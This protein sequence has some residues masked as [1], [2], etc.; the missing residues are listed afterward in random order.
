MT[1]KKE[2]VVPLIRNVVWR[3]VDDGGGEKKGGT[4]DAAT[5]D[6]KSETDL[7]LD[8]EAAEAILSGNR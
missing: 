1:E 6:A 2:Y 3:R 8:K 7:S 5:A 4:Q